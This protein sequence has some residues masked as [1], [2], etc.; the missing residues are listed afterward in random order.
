MS[1]GGDRTSIHERHR[2]HP[3]SHSP[4]ISPRRQPFCQ[5]VKLRSFTLA[6]IMLI[7]RARSEPRRT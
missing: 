6:S 3:H 7:C 5:G 2:I 1:S 4:V